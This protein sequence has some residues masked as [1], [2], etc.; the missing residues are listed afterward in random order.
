MLRRQGFDNQIGWKPLCQ[1]LHVRNQF[2]GRP[3]GIKET[4]TTVKGDFR[5]RDVICD[6]F[7]ITV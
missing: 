3:Q 1:L 6:D 2:R 5:I 7:K 4:N